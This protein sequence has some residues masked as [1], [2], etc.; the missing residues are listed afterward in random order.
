M[1]SERIFY[2]DANGV[3]IGTTRAV[4]GKH[5]YGI[6]NITSVSIASERRRLWPGI[7]VMVI[8]VGALIAGLIMDSFEVM[9]V[10]AGGFF[11]GTMYFR[12]RKPTYAVRI[13]TN[14]GPVLV[15]ASRQKWYVEQV[16]TAIQRSIDI[17]RGSG[18]RDPAPSA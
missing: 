16:K 11:G 2:S 14:R 13:V 15:L 18:Q 12:R 17:A 7:M 4:F 8:G 10:G 9:I 1:T 6:R 5:Q 3:R